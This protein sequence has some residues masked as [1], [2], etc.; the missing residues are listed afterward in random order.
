MSK[1]KTTRPIRAAAYMRTA[2]APQQDSVNSQRD[3]IRKY[4]TRHGMKI[5]KT[6]LDEGKSGLTIHGRE[7]FAQMMA[8]VQSGNAKF[9]CILLHDVSRW[10]RFQDPDESVHHEFICRK[11]GISIRYCA[12]QFDRR[13]ALFKKLR[14]AVVADYR[15]LLSLRQ[16]QARAA[17]SKQ[18]RNSG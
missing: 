1:T 17:R 5:V 12:E 2:T 3:A 4:A 6:Y 15:H 16:R 10:G 11:A 8:D 7:A 14:R 13:S 18:A 9:T